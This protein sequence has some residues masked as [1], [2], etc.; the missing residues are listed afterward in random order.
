MSHEQIIAI[1]IA[2]GLVAGVGIVV[3]IF[4]GVSGKLLSVPSDERQAAVPACRA[5]TA[6][7]AATPAV[8]DW[9]R[10]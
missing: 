8:T 6:A 10:Q 9:Q 2:S 3:G 7:G 1:V 4:L 5:T